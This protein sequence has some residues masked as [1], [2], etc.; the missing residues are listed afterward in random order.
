M[1]ELV[2]N[3]ETG[4]TVPPA[5]PAPNRQNRRRKIGKPVKKQQQLTAEQELHQIRAL[6]FQQASSSLEI[7]KTISEEAPTAHPLRGEISEALRLLRNA[8]TEA[9]VEF[10]R[11]VVAQLKRLEEKPLK[12]VDPPAD[13]AKHDEESSSL[14]G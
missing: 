6:I 12:L 9:G 3:P 13:A 8:Y 11:P 7:I 14:A 2:T 1:G 5:N 10:L 4:S